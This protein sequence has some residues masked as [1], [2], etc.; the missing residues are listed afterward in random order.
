MVLVTQLRMIRVRDGSFVLVLFLPQRARDITKAFVK[1]H[2]ITG[3]E[4]RNLALRE[5]THSVFK[6]N[7]VLSI[8]KFPLLQLVSNY[9]VNEIHCRV[10]LIYEPAL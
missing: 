1:L 6:F 5:D 7:F 8:L 3:E 2:F 4:K 9:Y 10:F